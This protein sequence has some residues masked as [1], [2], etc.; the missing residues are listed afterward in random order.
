MEE[1]SLDTEL[2]GFFVFRGG[3][4]ATARVASCRLACRHG[5]RCGWHDAAHRSADVALHCLLSHTTTVS[6]IRKRISGRSI[7]LE[8]NLVFSGRPPDVDPAP[9]RCCRQSGANGWARN[10]T[11]SLVAPAW[12]LP[13]PRGACLCPM[14]FLAAHR[15]RR[16]P[17]TTLLPTQ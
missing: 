14:A 17:M 13:H 9:S 7:E 4:L 15:E 6:A 10:D 16:Q 8:H 12:T 3:W 1:T 11:E 2:L 5:C